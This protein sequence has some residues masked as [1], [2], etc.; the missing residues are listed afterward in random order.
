MI[1]C[2]YHDYDHA[3]LIYS[4]GRR[5]ITSMVRAIIKPGSHGHRFTILANLTS[6]LTDL[7]RKLQYYDV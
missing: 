2:D 5:G 6:S 3:V 7:W 4:P 1:V